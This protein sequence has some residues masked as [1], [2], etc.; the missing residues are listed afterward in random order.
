MDTINAGKH[1]AVRA[2]EAEE[3]WI[4]HFFCGHVPLFSGTREGIRRERHRVHAWFAVV[5]NACAQTTHTLGPSLSTSLV[6]EIEGVIESG[7]GTGIAATY[8]ETCR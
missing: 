4:I 8:A 1:E 3:G 5:H 2:R 6:G 7:L